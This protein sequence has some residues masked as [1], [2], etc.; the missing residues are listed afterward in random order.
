MLDTL[1]FLQETKMKKRG[2]PRCYRSAFA[3]FKVITFYFTASNG[4]IS[5]IYLRLLFRVQLLA[6]N[7]TYISVHILQ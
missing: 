7:N 5:V 1:I 6:A 2:F 4:R 3:H